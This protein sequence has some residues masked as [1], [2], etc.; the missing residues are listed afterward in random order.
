L[1]QSVLGKRLQFAAA[2]RAGAIPLAL[3]LLFGGIGGPILASRI[4]E[5]EEVCSAKNRCEE[6]SLGHRVSPQ[7]QLRSEM[8]SLTTVISALIVRPLGHT[9]KPVFNALGGH[10][11]PNGLLAPLTC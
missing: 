2:R 11:L 7:R 9:Q 5:L 3:L 4:A 1:V 8:A 10:R 6:Q